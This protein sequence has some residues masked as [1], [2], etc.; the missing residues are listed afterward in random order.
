MAGSAFLHF[1]ILFHLFISPLLPLLMRA[2]HGAV[3]LFR[4]VDNARSL[5]RLDTFMSHALYGTHL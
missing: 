3:S 2:V 5:I 4:M 1:G